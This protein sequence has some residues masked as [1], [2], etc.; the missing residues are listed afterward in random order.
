VTYAK[1]S[2]ISI[3]RQT[4]RTNTKKIDQERRERCG[5][6]QERASIMKAKGMQ[7]SNR[8]ESLHKGG[9]N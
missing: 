5:P 7:A 4:G 6:R 1:K 3:I 8:K 9:E 2:G